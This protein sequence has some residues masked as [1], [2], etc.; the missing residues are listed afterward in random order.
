M[1]WWRSLS[2]L[3]SGWGGHNGLIG[4]YKINATSCSVQF[5]RSTHQI[6]KR[7]SDWEAAQGS[8]QQLP[9]NTANLPGYDAVPGNW[10]S[11]SD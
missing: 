3:R 4:V 10:L 7:S 1:I 11:S 6:N 5:Y 8:R 2:L 9:S